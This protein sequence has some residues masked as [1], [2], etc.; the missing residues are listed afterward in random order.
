MIY[1]SKAQN[2]IGKKS[3]DE[4]GR[5]KRYPCEVLDGIL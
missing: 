2:T 5:K 4:K 3:K 1:L